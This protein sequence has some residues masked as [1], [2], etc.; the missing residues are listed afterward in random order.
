MIARQQVIT[1][2]EFLSYFYDP[3]EGTAYG[4]IFP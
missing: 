4:F 2:V 3:G 1:K